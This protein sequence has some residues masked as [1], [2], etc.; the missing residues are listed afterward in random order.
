MSLLFD[1]FSAVS[2][3]DVEARIR[4]RAAQSGFDLADTVVTALAR[5]ARAVLRENEQLNLTSITEPEEFIERHLGEAFEGAAMLPEDI[6]GQCLDVGSGNGYPAFPLAVARPGLRLLLAE[7]SGR[8]ADFLRSVIRDAG[9]DSAA[10]L[11]TQVQRASDLADV[12]RCRVITSRALGGWPKIFPRLRSCLEDGGDILVWAGE[13]MEKILRREVW[14]KLH[15]ED[16]RALP[17][18][19]KS[20]VWRFRVAGP[21]ATRPDA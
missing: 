10:V 6:E 5:H 17:A 3:F 20:W 16:R 14:K 21:P 2:D 13:E 19:E 7:A 11:E 8:K 4:S 12:G 18:A 1:P 9:F 15:L